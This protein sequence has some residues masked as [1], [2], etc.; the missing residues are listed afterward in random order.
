MGT[1][2]SRLPEKIVAGLLG[3]FL[4]AIVVYQLYVSVYASMKTETV[5]DY[6]VS[7]TIPVEGFAIRYETAI[8]GEYTG[9]ENCIYNDGTWVS[10]GENVVEFYT[11]TQSD[12]NLN[13]AKELESEIKMLEEAQDATINN[14]STTEILNRDIKEQL[15]HLTRLSSLGR[16]KSSD[17]IRTSLT[18]LINKKQIAT[19]MADNYEKRITALKSEYDMLDVTEN[20]EKI[21]LAKAPVSGYFSKTVDGYETELNP[22][23]TEDFEIYDYLELFDSEPVL[24]PT[25]SV[26]KIVMNPRWLF[27]AAA[28]KQNLEYVLPG[29]EVTLGFEHIDRKIPA[30]VLEVMQDKDDERAVIVLNCD[31]ITGDLL[32][33]R[34]AQAVINFNQYTGLRIDSN[35]IRFVGDKRGVYILDSSTVYFKEIDPIYEETG[36]VLSKMIPPDIKNDQFVKLFDQVITKGNDLYD[37]KVIQ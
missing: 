15:G 33:I 5:F 26:G 10:V 30:T 17:E 31:Q 3:V 28:P 32:T 9:I 16:Y 29:Q 36:F 22:D 1:A 19:G 35:H 4:L 7:R 24:S 27:A 23:M 8:S 21:M 14:F 12:Q 6:T 18:S 11:S 20:T 25:R 13:R 34:A 2:I 37:G